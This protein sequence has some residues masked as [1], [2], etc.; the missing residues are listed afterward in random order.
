MKVET[1]LG[2]CIGPALTKNVIQKLK[3]EM[4]NDF[5]F[6]QEAG[7]FSLFSSKSRLQLY[8]LL[9]KVKELCVCDIALVL[10]LTPSSISQHLSKLKANRLV[11]ARREGQTVF[12]S[13]TAHAF[14]TQFSTFLTKWHI[15]SQEGT[16]EL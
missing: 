11:N 4:K 14:N 6:D 2:T 15:Y 9:L 7:L 12:Y 10:T 1:V 5:S 16:H 8:F 13:L 3:K